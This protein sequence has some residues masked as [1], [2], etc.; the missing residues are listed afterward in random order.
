MPI[1]RGI[2]E[3]SEIWPVK[4][5][6]GSTASFRTFSSSVSGD[7]P[8]IQVNIFQDPIPYKIRYLGGKPVCLI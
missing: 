7:I 2:G 1:P 5:S 8:T 3:L 6:D 4:F